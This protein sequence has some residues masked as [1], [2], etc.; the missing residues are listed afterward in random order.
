MSDD[1]DWFKECDQENEP[2]PKKARSH[3]GKE[4]C[5]SE[6]DVEE[7]LDIVIKKLDVIEHKMNIFERLRK[8]GILYL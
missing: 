4:K 1:T 3:K 5:R 8:S 2:P 6:S 7:R